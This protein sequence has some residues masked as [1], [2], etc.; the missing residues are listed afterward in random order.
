MPKP[1]PKSPFVKRGKQMQEVEQPSKNMAEEKRMRMDEWRKVDG[2]I[3]N[4]FEDARHEISA[5]LKMKEKEMTN[6]LNHILGTHSALSSTQDHE[7][8]PPPETPEAL[9]AE[10]SGVKLS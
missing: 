4:M 1:R 3:R 8:P 2:A 7:E 5:L 10:T 9:Q 6:E